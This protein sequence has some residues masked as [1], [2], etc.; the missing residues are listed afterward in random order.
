MAVFPIHLH[1]EVLCADDRDVGRAA[2]HR[3]DV[4]RARDDG[5]RG[6]RDVR[7]IEGEA[8]DALPDEGHRE[9]L[10]RTG[11]HSGPLVLGDGQIGGWHFHAAADGDRRRA[12]GAC[13][14]DSACPSGGGAACDAARSAGALAWDPAAGRRADAESEEER[15]RRAGAEAVR[16]KHRARGYHRSRLA[17]STAKWAVSRGASAPSDGI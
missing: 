13:R 10:S 6:A 1:E 16:S 14:A 4:G 5:V 12:A 17:G 15:E 8:R 9:G 11:H 3:H 7:Q 2:D